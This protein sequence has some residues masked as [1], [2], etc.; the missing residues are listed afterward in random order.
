MAL[1]KLSKSSLNNKEIQKVNKVLKKEFLGMGKEVNSF[2][3]KLSNYF[4]RD[5]VC[6]VNGF[7]ALH[8]ALEANEIGV[9]DEVLVPSLTYVATFQAI[10]AVG[11][12]PVSCDIDLET[13]NISVS[14]IKKKIS[15]KTKAI[16]PVWFGG[17]PEGIFDIYRI[18]KTFNIRVIEDSAHAFGSQIKNKLIGSFGNISCFSFD[19]IK[20]ITSGEGGCIVSSDKRIIKKIKEK[21]VLGIRLKHANKKWQPQVNTQG[22]RYHMS[23]IMAAIGLVQFD[24]KNLL[25]KKR[26]SIAKTYD[27]MLIDNKSYKIFKRDYNKINPHIYPILNLK[28]STKKLLVYMK[29]NN[30]EV[31]RHY[32]PNHLLNKFWQPTK[33]ENTENIFQ[34]IVTLPLNVDMTLDDVGFVSSRIQEYI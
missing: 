25:K 26:Q 14:E 10:S 6:V 19:G 30:I 24:K 31:G 7:A 29:K 28:K 4:K 12:K 17:N 22:W 18:A 9:D 5:V 32:F 8:L 27:K 33:L 16:M 20:N 11:A 3:N 21:R 34:K 13:L 1:I 2:E 23:N 15:S